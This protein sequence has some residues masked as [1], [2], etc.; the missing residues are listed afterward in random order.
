MWCHQE[1]IEWVCRRHCLHIV[2]LW[3]LLA[4][5]VILSENRRPKKDLVHCIALWN[6]EHRSREKLLFFSLAN[7]VL[8]GISI[9][10]KVFNLIWRCSVIAGLLG[11]W[12]CYA[13]SATLPLSTTKSWISP[14]QCRVCLDL[15]PP[16]T[17]VLICFSFPW[18]PVFTDR[19][20]RWWRRGGTETVG[21]TEILPPEE[22]AAA[23]PVTGTPEEDW[24]GINWEQT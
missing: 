14:G 12:S 19:L 13:N 21:R 23:S 4:W 11:R 8:S 5:K 1:S 6:A 3:R 17:D 20:W 2:E 24:K 9:I 18:L 10:D 16:M 7:R 22:P 15:Q